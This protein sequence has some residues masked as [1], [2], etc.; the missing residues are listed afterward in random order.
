MTDRATVLIEELYQAELY[1]KQL[2]L[3]TL[4]DKID[5]IFCTILWIPL[6]GLQRA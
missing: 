3:Q 2:E 1:R 4:R 5:R 6:T